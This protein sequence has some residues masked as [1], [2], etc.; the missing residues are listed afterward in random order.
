MHRLCS[1]VPAVIFEP[2]T[3]GLADEPA[4]CGG[5]TS[6]IVTRASVMWAPSFPWLGWPSEGQETVPSSWLLGGSA[7]KTLLEE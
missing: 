3:T 2:R 1:A 7:R 5:D 4:L 6:F